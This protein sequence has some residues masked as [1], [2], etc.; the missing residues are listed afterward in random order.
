MFYIIKRWRSKLDHLF[1]LPAQFGTLQ[2]KLN[3]ME[4][5][6]DAL[7]WETMRHTLR[8]GLSAK[9]LARIE[10]R[11]LASTTP[12]KL[13]DAEFQI[14][15]QWGEDG[16]I[17]YLLRHVS[18]PCKTFVEFGVESYAEANTRWLVEG[19]QWSGLI[20]DGSEEHISSVKADPI[21]WQNQLHATCTFITAENINQLITD[22]GIAGE[23]GLLSVDLDGVDYWIWKAIHV[24]NPAIVIA[25]YNSL[26]GP[27]HSV[28][29]P[30]D[31][32]FVRSKAHFS[33]SY[34]GASLAALVGL[35]K[36]KGYAFV[37]SN[38]AGSNAF[39]VRKDLLKPPLHEISAA[40]GYVRRGFR[41]ARSPEGT[42][43]MPTHE[44][45][46]ALIE[47]LPLVSVDP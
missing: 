15:S 11:L 14:Y 39:F 36:T 8:A 43:S 37:G 12:Q 4:Q 22:A 45:E 1:A 35:G 29:V 13:A 47:G 25:E 44:Q 9:A 19:H 23:I 41:E 42:L 21:F 6:L 7:H 20:I 27:E 40:V 24:V 10:E 18:V 32:G 16:I 38:S 5:K 3:R 17:Q 34:Y 2:D 26:F 33:M 28:T 46:A 30:Y 31:A